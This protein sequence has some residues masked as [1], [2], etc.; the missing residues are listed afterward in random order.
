MTKQKRLACPMCDGGELTLI[1]DVL[2]SQEYVRGGFAVRGQPLPIR[3]KAVPFL[4]CASCE[5]CIE[6]D[7]TTMTVRGGVA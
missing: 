1:T 6:V 4:A 3:M 2:V 7:P 5:F